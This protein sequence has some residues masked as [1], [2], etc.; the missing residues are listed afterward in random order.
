LSN[1]H[2]I[3]GLIFSSQNEI[4]QLQEELTQLKQSDE[5]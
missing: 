3:L 1:F 5:E 2:V 4:E